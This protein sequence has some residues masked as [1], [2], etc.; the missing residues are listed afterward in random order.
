MGSVSSFIRMQQTAQHS[1]GEESRTQFSWRRDR[2]RRDP[3]RTG[4]GLDALL[5]SRMT[6]RE[7]QDLNGLEPEANCGH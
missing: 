7:L 5:S 4:P 2:P 1:E 6:Q 3:H